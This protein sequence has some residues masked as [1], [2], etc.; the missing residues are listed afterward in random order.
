[1]QI[2]YFVKFK[3]VD[4]RKYYNNKQDPEADTAIANSNEENDLNARELIYEKNRGALTFQ[5][6]SESGCNFI[7]FKFPLF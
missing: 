3:G 5:F 6:R 2:A 7:L 1:M 4:N